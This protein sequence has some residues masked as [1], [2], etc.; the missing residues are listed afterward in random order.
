MNVL[1]S[2]LAS[3]TYDSG[4]VIA[5]NARPMAASRAIGIASRKRVV[6]SRF[7]I[8]PRNT[9]KPTTMGAMRSMATSA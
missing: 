6:R 2:P 7:T 4:V 8:S 5:L 9:M 1:E 3:D